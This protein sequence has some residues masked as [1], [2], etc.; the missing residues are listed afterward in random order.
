MV[1]SRGRDSRGSALPLRE[2]LQSAKLD[3]GIIDVVANSLPCLTSSVL[4]S[5]DMIILRTFSRNSVLSRNPGQA[6]NEHCK[7]WF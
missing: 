4:K 2:D 6:E 7:C 1:G 5:K 3:L